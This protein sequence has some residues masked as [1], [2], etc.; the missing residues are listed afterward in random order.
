[1][2]RQAVETSPSDA[3]GY[4]A[5]ANC[6]LTARRPETA[7]EVCAVGLRHAGA[8]TALLCAQAAVLQSLSRVGEA[9]AAYRAALESDPSNAQ[10][11]HGVALQAVETGDWD[12]AET[13]V[14]PLA[15]TPALDWLAARIALGRGDLETALAK[16]KRAESGM[17][18]AD[19]Q[20]EAALLAGEA[21]DGLGRPA[22]AF[23]AFARGKARLRTFYAERAAG[24]E[25]ETDKLAR[26]AAWFEAAEP[27]P[28][29]DA[30]PTVT[31]PGVRG[32]AFLLG[33]PRSGTTLLEQAL[34][35]H[36]D[37]VALEEAPTLAEAYDAF[38]ADAAG[39]ARLARSH[40]RRGRALARGLLAGRGGARRR[41]RAAASSSTRRRPAR[42]TCR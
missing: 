17:S 21:L 9:A 22:E 27:S 41:R 40:R 5:L 25:S 30:P 7:L 10:A 31:D 6:L 4:V 2:F 38:L 19:Q 28:W 23:A 32:H 33:F 1:M 39:L 36:P 18:R 35:G 14:A 12:E 26:L 13:L 11:R 42:S 37:L 29:R 8:T 16:A 15:P 3:E 20:A 24:R 34:A